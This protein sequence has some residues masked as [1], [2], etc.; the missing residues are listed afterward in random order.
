MSLRDREVLDLL[1][2]EPEL[3]AIAD[4]VSDTENGPRQ[5]R[6]FRAIVAVTLA[7]A[8]IFVL[9][10]AAP[11]DSGGGGG[12]GSVLDRALAAIDSSGPVT[13]M[14]MGLDVTRAGHTF[15]SIVMESFYDKRA[16]LV[17]VVSRSDGKVLG[18]YTTAAAEDEFSFFPGLLEGAAFYKDALANGDARIVGQGQWHGMPVYWVELAKGGGLILRVGIDRDSYRPVVFRALNPDGSFAGFQVGVLGFD[19]VSNAQANF[20]TAASVLVSGRVLGPDCRPAKARVGAFLGGEEKV[21]SSAEIASARTGANGN[22]TLTADPRRSPFREALAA[23]GGRVNVELYV[24]AGKDA[25]KLIGFTRF[26]RAAKGGRWVE[27]APVTI[28]ASKG[29]T[30]SRC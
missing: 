24:I 25:P 19:Y 9:V 13:H 17:R 10:L 2:D 7:A 14:T 21:E 22:F 30:A 4:A 15:P 1:R 3:L 26:S 20:D 28:H 12:R 5:L 16:G 11:W 8:A 27:G 6:P 18:D 23:N 29:A